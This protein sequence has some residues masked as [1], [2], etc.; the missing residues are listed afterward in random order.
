M[1]DAKEHEV[2]TNRAGQ[3][4]TE[5]DAQALSLRS[6][7]SLV[8]RFNKGAANAEDSEL[9]AFLRDD[10]LEQSLAASSINPVSFEQ[11]VRDF[12]LTGDAAES[13]GNVGIH[14]RTAQR[15]VGRFVDLANLAIAGRKAAEA[16]EAA[17]ELICDRKRQHKPSFGPG[18]WSSR[19]LRTRP[20][21]F[22]PDL[23]PGSP[24]GLCSG[25]PRRHVL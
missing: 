24:G 14:E 10:V 19:K 13:A 4:D 9:F 20:L 8:K 7:A 22:D 18:K 2:L 3:S 17:C 11:L 16:A 6:L 23:E 25:C 1:V 15:W 12:F 5:T 21:N